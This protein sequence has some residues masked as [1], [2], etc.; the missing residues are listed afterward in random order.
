MMQRP[1]LFTAGI[2]PAP[3]LLRTVKATKKGTGAPVG[4]KETRVCDSKSMMR[5]PQ[6]SATSNFISL[7][8]SA[9]VGFALLTGAASSAKFEDGFGFGLNVEIKTK[10]MLMQ[11][12]FI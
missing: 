3:K 12:P 1:R 6:M 5:E 7:A 11:S 9:G 2:K 8:S 4:D 10:S